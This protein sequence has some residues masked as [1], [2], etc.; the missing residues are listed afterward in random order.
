ML[1]NILISPP[2]KEDMSIIYEALSFTNASPVCLTLQEAASLD[3]CYVAS[4]HKVPHIFIKPTGPIENPISPQRCFD[5][6]ALIPF[7]QLHH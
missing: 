6:R 7:L 3:S 1:T 4:L 5:M 2:Q